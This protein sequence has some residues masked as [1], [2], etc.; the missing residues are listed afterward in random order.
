LRILHLADLHLDTSFAGMGFPAELSRAYRE[1]LRE[2]LKRIIDLALKEGVQVVTIAGDLYEHERYSRDTGQFLRQQFERLGDTPVIIAPGN[3]DPWLPDSLYAQ[4]SWPRNVHIFQEAQLTPHR[5]ADGLTLWGVAHQSLDVR[6]NFLE[7]FRVPS[8]GI[9]LLLMHGS[10][11][12]RIPEGKTPH[13]PFRPEEIRKAGFHF[14][15]LGHYHQGR[16]SPPD[17]PFLAYPGSPEPLSF[18]EGEEHGVLLLEVKGESIQPEL[19]R[20]NHNLLRCLEIDISAFSTRDQIREQILALQKDYPADKSYV[21]VILKGQTHP[22]LEPDPEALEAS[23]EGKFRHLTIINQAQAPY[24]LQ[25]LAEEQTVRGAFVRRM[26]EK[27]RTCSEA[28]Q[29]LLK[30]ALIYGLQ[31]FER[32]PLIQR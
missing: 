6:Q 7:G 10:D 24:D 27:L 26:L 28:E 16:L 11:T 23:L 12:S 3:H 1:S 13:G 21:R 8:E 2:A 22:D 30:D 20:L 14:A 9:H 25:A 29:A 32:K 18:S 15:L 19:R 5:L 17:A 31:A 4:I